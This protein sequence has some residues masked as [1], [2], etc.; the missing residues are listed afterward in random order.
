MNSPEQDIVLIRKYHNGTLSPT[1]KNQL[2]ARSLDDIFL[3]DALE[4]YE[5]LGVKDEDAT[6]LN[7]KLAARIASA[8]I[9]APIWGFKQWGIAASV[10]LCIALGSIYF[11]QNPKDQ[12]IALND[13]Q[14]KEDIP[15]AEKSKITQLENTDS[16]NLNRLAE[17]TR[18]TETAESTMLAD[19]VESYTPEPDIVVEL[20]AVVPDKTEL[21]TNLEEVKVVGYGPQKKQDLVGAVTS[22]TSENLMAAR[23]IRV[24]KQVVNVKL[25]GKIIDEKDR[26]TLPGVSIKNLESG[27][28]KQTD[29][30]GEFTIEL[31]QNDNL[32]FSYLGYETKNKTI[33][34]IDEPVTIALK[35]YTSTLSE[36]VVVRYGSPKAVAN[37]EI[38]PTVGWR[39][40]KSY[41]DKQAQLANIGR[42]KVQVQFIINT[43]SELSD[44]KIID[45]FSEKAGVAAINIIK[46]YN[47]GW[48]GSADKIPHKA[49]ITIKFK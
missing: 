42:G 15:R 7:N 44:F 23:M 41:V 22:V 33:Q 2:E 19:K 31:N 37:N 48:T 20:L 16:S 6:A 38:G 5:E 10:L 29:A 47:S 46:N 11:N 28:I 13:I 4:G 45:S 40:F 36:T 27:V 12:T 26:S 43:N 14:Q 32:A 8:K 9:I 39:S 17:V 1:E 35:P 24:D 18:P 25:K 3:Q 49:N 30:N 21:P 34:K